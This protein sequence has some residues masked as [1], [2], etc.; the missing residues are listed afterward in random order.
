MVF[1]ESRKNGRVITGSHALSAAD[2]DCFVYNRFVVF[3]GN[4]PSATNPETLP[5]SHTFFRIGIGLRRRMLFQFTGNRTAA[6]RHIF[7]SASEARFHM[8]FKVSEKNNF[9]R[10]QNSGCDF[11]FFDMFLVDLDFFIV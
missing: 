11:C 6:H 3:H 7:N 4:S 2:T 8:S 1:V 10:F 9:I 5:A